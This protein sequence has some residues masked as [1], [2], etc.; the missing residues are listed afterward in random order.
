MRQVNIL[1]SVATM[2]KLLLMAAMILCVGSCAVDAKADSDTEQYDSLLLR[3]G[4]MAPDFTIVNDDYPDG[5]AISSLRGKY[6]VLEFWASWCPDCRRITPAMVELHDR[7]ASDSVVFIGVSFDTD[8]EKWLKYV[9]DSGMKWL[10]HSELKKWKKETT[11]DGPY[12]VQWIPTMYLI[13]KQ[14]RIVVGTVD[15]GKLKAALEGIG[16][17]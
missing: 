17:Q 14:G 1:F 4:E 15:E 7:F 16:K 10:Q 3:Q 8:K 12:K 2:K 11:I 6:V 13:D 9:K 5:L